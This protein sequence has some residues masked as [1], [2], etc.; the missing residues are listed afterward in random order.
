MLMVG[1][2]LEIGVRARVGSC[3]SLPQGKRGGVPMAHDSRAPGCLGF[4]AGR[5]SF[6]E[7]TRAFW[8]PLHGTVLAVLHFR[9]PWGAGLVMSCTVG[10]AGRV[11]CVRLGGKTGHI[12]VCGKGGFSCSG[13]SGSCWRLQLVPIRGGWAAGP[14]TLLWPLGRMI[15]R[16][17]GR[18]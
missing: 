14:E 8:M 17:F 10:R 1:D 13:D 11:S 9:W 5:W 2:I 18:R 3:A 16:V 6:L 4:G 15:G 12:V 7:E